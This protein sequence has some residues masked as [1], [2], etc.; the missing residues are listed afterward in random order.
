MN[1]K[2]LMIFLL[3][4]F[5][6]HLGCG[7]SSVSPNFTV[8]PANKLPTGGSDATTIWSSV[9]L[10]NLEISNATLDPIFSHNTVA[11]TAQVPNAVSAITIKPTAEDQAATIV[12]DGQTVT[13][14]QYSNPINLTAG[15]PKTIEIKITSSQGDQTKTYSVTVTREP[16]NNANLA[17][18][19]INNATVLPTFDKTR[20][21]Y[22]G[23]VPFATT[24]ISLSPTVEES[25]ATLKINN[26]DI[27]SG[28]IVPVD[29][30]PGYN[31]INILVTAQN[32]ID[33][34]TYSVIITRGNSD[35]NLLAL[36]VVDLAFTSIDL[37][38]SFDQDITTYVAQL[39]SATSAI[40][41]SPLAP[42]IYAETTVNGSIIPYGMQSNNIDMVSGVNTIVIH[43]TSSDTNTQKTY[44]I[45][46]VKP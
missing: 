12:V 24:Q 1:K 34:K 42:D 40:R 4:S 37:T 13:T 46:A 23:I 41:I 27:L 30:V 15:V 31:I 10:T 17:D 3:S 29:L 35:A 16:S 19:I 25:A 44:T 2:L 36:N 22:S 21:I 38:P 14:G 20:L 33:A 32:G 7:T 6:L 45:L 5:L 9:L 18:L 39:N 28:D 11:Y 43:V 8:S 26:S